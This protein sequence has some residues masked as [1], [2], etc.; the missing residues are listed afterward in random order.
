MKIAIGI[1][2]YKIKKEFYKYLNYCIK[3]NPDIDFKIYIKEDIKY[4]S[5]FT[6]NRLTKLAELRNKLTDEILKDNETEHFD[7]IVFVDDDLY[8][9]AGIFYELKKINNREI[10]A[11]GIIPY[12]I[13]HGYLIVDIK[14]NIWNELP[15]DTAG[16]EIFKIEKNLIPDQM[17]IIK[18][19]IFNQIEKPYFKYEK[20]YRF[21]TYYFAFKIAEITDWHIINVINICDEK[22]EE[23]QMTAFDLMKKQNSKPLF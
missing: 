5:E 1:V 15:Q 21:E 10:K 4:D 13:G 12:S 3:L 20:E 17:W 6:E 16:K 18:P 9:D 8:L 14:G 11:L 22:R 2:R 19:E 7:W 23:D